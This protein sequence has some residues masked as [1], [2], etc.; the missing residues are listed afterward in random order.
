MDWSNEPVVIHAHIPKTAGSSLNEALR[1][2][3]AGKRTVAYN[4]VGQEAFDA[5]S[6]QDRHA[7]DLIYGHFVF[8]MH[9]HLRP[10][11]LYV[12]VLREPRARIYSYFRYLQ[13]QADHPAHQ[14]VL[15]MSFG[16]FLEQCLSHEALRM[17]VDNAQVRFLCGDAL[18]INASP[19]EK[20]EAA[21]ANAGG[22][23][24]FGLTERF[25][26]FFAKLRGRGIVTNGRPTREN[27]TD[28]GASFA[29]HLDELTNQQKMA[30]N[31]FC[32]WDD[33]LYAHC[34]TIGLPSRRRRQHRL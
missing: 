26:S 6:E 9:R 7:I 23:A 22:N 1:N 17:D 12:F 21:K 20:L 3:Y 25:D 14:L 15:P 31:G 29:R 4:D 2:R 8:G 27:T 34:A 24:I 10:N 5:M 32:E 30:L 13:L 28:S 18:P 33:A 16:T 19:S 11:H